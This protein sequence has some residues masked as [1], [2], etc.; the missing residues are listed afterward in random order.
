MTPLR[1][2]RKK[3]FLSFEERYFEPVSP[4]HDRNLTI[5]Y[6][7]PDFLHNKKFSEF[8]T[9]HIDLTR[10]EDHLFKDCAKNTRY[11]I[12]RLFNKDKLNCLIAMKPNLEMINTFV[13]FYNTFAVSKGLSKCNTQKIE[14]LAENNGIVF[15]VVQNHNMKAIC[16]HAYIVN[17]VR[18]RLLHSVSQF[19]DIKDNAER[20]LIGRAN[21]GLHWFDIKHFKSDGYKI[22]DMG[23]LADLDLNPNLGNINKFKKDFG[24]KEII[25]YNVY[26]P[27]SI[28]GRFATY[29]LLKKSKNDKLNQ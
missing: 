20:N 5:Y 2:N 22:Y 10:P 9:L 24:G 25:E 16:Y 7:S 14:R 1:I 8:K 19:R 4:S 15:S 26:L 21:R 18:S 3:W 23:G 27:N 29:L 17:G 28:L 13:S 12:N 11:E 6:Q